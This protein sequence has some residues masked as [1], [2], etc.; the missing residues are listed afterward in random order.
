MERRAAAVKMEGRVLRNTF[1]HADFQDKAA[2]VDQKGRQGRRISLAF[3]TL[4]EEATIGMSR[5]LL[6]F[7]SVAF[8]PRVSPFLCVLCVKKKPLEF[9][10]ARG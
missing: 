8:S 5:V 6:W 2:L 7:G 3:P 9:P 10:A 4:N 1:H